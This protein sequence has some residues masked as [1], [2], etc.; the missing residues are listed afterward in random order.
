MRACYQGNIDEVVYLLN[1]G[2]D[3]NAKDNLGKTARDYF[4]NG[5][6]E[7]LESVIWYERIWRKRYT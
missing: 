2:A 5:V 1:K 6:P 7:E 3:K 4:R